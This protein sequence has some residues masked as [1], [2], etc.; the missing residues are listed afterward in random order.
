MLHYQDTPLPFM[1]RETDCMHCLMLSDCSIVVR[2]IM[3]A[4]SMARSLIYQILTE[5]V[6]NEI[7]LSQRGV[8]IAE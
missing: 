7:G 8:D 6:E 2:I 4:H 1:E 3:E 5:K